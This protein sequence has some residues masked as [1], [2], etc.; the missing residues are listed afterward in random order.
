[1]KKKKPKPV[2]A[3][4]LFDKDKVVEVSL[5]KSN[6]PEAGKGERIVK[7]KLEI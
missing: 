6:L 7:V 2:Y 3:Y 5:D 1:M 4:A